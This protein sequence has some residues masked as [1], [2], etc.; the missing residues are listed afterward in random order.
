[1]KW[2]I[3][4]PFHNLVYSSYSKDKISIFKIDLIVNLI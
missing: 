4:N 3:S 2:T 1:M